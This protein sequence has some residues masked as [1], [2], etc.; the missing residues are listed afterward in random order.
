MDVPAFTCA[1]AKAEKHAWSLDKD[2]LLNL[3]LH[4]CKLFHAVVSITACLS[5]VTGHCN[6]SG[7]N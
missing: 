4:D 5:T 1:F 3:A 2:P 7:F 6:S